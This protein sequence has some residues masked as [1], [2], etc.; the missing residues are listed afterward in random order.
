MTLIEF[1]KREYRIDYFIT[2]IALAIVLFSSLW[3][4]VNGN[5]VRM[6]HDISKTAKELEQTKVYNAELRNEL[7]VLTEKENGAEFLTSKGLM[8]D[9]SPIYQKNAQSVSFMIE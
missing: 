8:L 1:G 9:K 5:I 4:V 7:Y 6:K 3:L 2:T